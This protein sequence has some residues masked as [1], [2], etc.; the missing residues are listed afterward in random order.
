MLRICELL[1]GFGVVGL[2]AAATALATEYGTTR[3]AKTA[4]LMSS[5]IAIVSIICDITLAME[6]VVEVVEKAIEAAK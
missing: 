4:Y 5:V 1:I 2:V 6:F 3:A